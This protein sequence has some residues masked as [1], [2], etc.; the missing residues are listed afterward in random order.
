[1][2]GHLQTR[3]RHPLHPD[4]DLCEVPKGSFV[5]SAV[6]LAPLHHPSLPDEQLVPAWPSNAPLPLR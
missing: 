4:E 6:S 5:G 3:V 1:M 2:A